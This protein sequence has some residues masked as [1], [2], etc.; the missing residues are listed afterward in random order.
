[1]GLW[2]DLEDWLALDNEVNAE[3][4]RIRDQLQASLQGDTI[5]LDRARGLAQTFADICAGRNVV[6]HRDGWTGWTEVHAEIARCERE[7]VELFEGSL[8]EAI[9]FELDVGAE[10]DW[11]NYSLATGVQ[12][13]GH[14]DLSEDFVLE[15]DWRLGRLLEMNSPRSLDV[16]LADFER[17]CRRRTDR[18]EDGSALKWAREEMLCL[19]EQMERA[20][21][22]QGE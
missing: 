2:S 6:P 16:Q 20:T 8:V 9:M 19:I 21:D 7:L 12:W 1:M 5:F 22:S 14:H 18:G 3:L 13:H 10:V 17:A 4:F 11:V 15:H